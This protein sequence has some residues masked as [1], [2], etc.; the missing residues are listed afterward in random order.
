MI[1][2]LAVAESVIVI[3]KLNDSDTK[4]IVLQDFVVGGENVIPIF[5]DEIAFKAQTEGSGFENDGVEIKANFLLSLLQG[6]E[7]FLLN[8]GG[9]LPQ[10]I[11]APELKNLLNES[12]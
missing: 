3:S 12:P 2:K 6:H 5:L 9:A 4:S 7:I 8:P 1:E 10:R 11:S